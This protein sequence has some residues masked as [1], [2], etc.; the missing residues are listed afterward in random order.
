MGKIL[1]ELLRDLYSAGEFLENRAFPPEED[2]FDYFCEVL[3][4]TRI[5]LIENKINLWEKQ[6]DG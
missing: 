2:D 3:K 4:R 1:K 6:D 5:S